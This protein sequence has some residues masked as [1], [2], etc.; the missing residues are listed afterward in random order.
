MLRDIIKKEILEGITSAKFV[1]TFLLWGILILVSV[2][3]GITNYSAEQKEYATAV[4]KVNSS[5]D[6]SLV[7]S[8]YESNPVLCPP[9]LAQKAKQEFNK[10]GFSEWIGKIMKE[11][12]IPG[13]GIAVIKEGKVVFSEGFGLRDVKRGLKVTPQSLFPIASCTK[14]FTAVSLAML[15]D[16]GKADWDIPVREYI[17][18]LRLYD[19]YATNH[20]TLRDLLAHRSGLPQHDR[21]YFNRN[22]TRNEI[23]E[24]LRFL[25]PSKDVRERFQYANLNYM[26]AAYLL[27]QVTN[28]SWEDF[29]RKK[30]FDPLEMKNSNCSVIESQRTSDYALP[31]REDDGKVEEIH[32][33]DVNK[34]G[35]GPAGSVNS[36]LADMA[37]WLLFHLNKGKFKGHQIV[38]E[39]NLGVTHTPQIILPGGITDEMFYSSYGMGWGITSYRNHLMLSHGGGFDGFGCFVSILPRDQIGCV[40]LCNMEGSLLPYILTY[41]IYDRLLDLSEIHWNERMK[42]RIAK[43]KASG[44]KRNE[45]EIFRQGGQTSDLLEKYCGKFEHPAYGVLSIEKEG[46]RLKL[47]HNNLPSFLVHLY[48]D[49][50]ETEDKDFGRFRISFISDEK[51]AVVRIEVPF[52]PSVKNIVFKRLL[53]KKPI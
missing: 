1:F 42:E 45:E 26:I 10:Q 38:S 20:I 16:E 36:N 43:V 14:T 34:M 19:E 51:G 18:S 29:V 25:E 11:W 12:R 4:A 27:E 24:R 13:L 28:M 53:E 41:T 44:T 46:N 5:S 48:Y 2:Y 7:D 50:F 40:V 23:M 33:F 35:M 37:N 47:T 9:L 8:K 21:M 6:P 39:V 15:V 32:F 30:I 3:A 49:V 31:Y 17:P 22:I 52:E